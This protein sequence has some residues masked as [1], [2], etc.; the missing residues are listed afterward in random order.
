MINYYICVVSVVVL[1]GMAPIGSYFWM[2]D[3][4]IVVLFD[5]D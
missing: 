5:R 2:H 1:I 4:Y 3:Q